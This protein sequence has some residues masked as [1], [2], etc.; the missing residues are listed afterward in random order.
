MTLKMLS[1]P[2]TMTLTKF[3][4]QNFLTNTNLSPYSIL[5]NRNFDDLDHL[6]KCKNKVFGIIAVSETRITKQTSLATNINL[7]NY[8]IEFTPTESSA[9]GM[10]LYIAIHLSYKLCPDLNIFKDNHLLCHI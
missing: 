2:N 9:V 6:L 5:I 1:T 10:L 4:L 7:K 3:K 8:T